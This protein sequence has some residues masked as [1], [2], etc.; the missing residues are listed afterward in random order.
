MLH[1]LRASFPS[2]TI[3]WAV[4]KSFAPLLHGHPYID[5]L[6][7]LP[8]KKMGHCLKLGNELRNANY[9]VVL[10]AQ[11]LFVSGLVS[12]L[13]NAP[14]RVGYNW[15]REANNIFMTDASVVATD[16]VHMVE[17]IL[18]LGEAIGIQRQ[19]FQ[20]DEF[21]ATMPASSLEKAER[22]RYAALVVGASIPSK[23]LSPEHWADVG[24]QLYEDGYTPIL[25]GGPQEQAVAE[26]ISSLIAYPVINLAGKTSFVELA[27]VLSQA[28]VVIS[29]DT[30]ALHLAVAVGTPS[31]G[32]FG[33]TDP[34][35]TGNCWG[36]A[37]HIVLDAGGSAEHRNFRNTKPDEKVVD[38]I[39]TAEII[40]AARKVSRATV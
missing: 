31:V 16:R 6:H 4:Q 21:L 7:V 3:G 12:R 13:S 34:V 32:L 28:A 2:A 25:I 35:R 27:A 17:K 22:S 24:M 5:N 40:A 1:G 33:V 30:G 19:P 39:Q 18:R 26:N 23:T 37:P 29:S 14:R 15:R 20:R 8:A 9:D 36:T 11:G 10:D 38:R